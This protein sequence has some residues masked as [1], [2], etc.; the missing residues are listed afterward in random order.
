MLI[1]S[2]R[3]FFHCSRVSKKQEHNI[4]LAYI[5]KSMPIA[6]FSTIVKKIPKGSERP[7]YLKNHANFC[8]G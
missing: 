5:E 6:V 7:E 8:T 2:A 4:M 3:C 1:N